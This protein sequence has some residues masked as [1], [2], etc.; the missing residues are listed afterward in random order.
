MRHLALLVLLLISSSLARELRAQASEPVGSE[1]MLT[2]GDSV[3]VIV[4]RKPEFSGEFAVAADGSVSHPLYRDVQVGGVSLAVAQ[5][6]MRAY[7]ERYDRAP[8]FVM[9]PLF[10]VA[11]QGEVYRP[12]VYAL[13]PQ[14]SIAEAVAQAG[15]PTQ[16]GRADRVRLV[17]T[18]TNGSQQQFRVDLTHPETGAARMPIRSGDQIVVERKRSVFSEVIVPALTIVGAAAS[19]GIFINNNTK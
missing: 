11:I 4:W 14:T 18:G 6:N 13:G 7:L 19:I 17:R 10:R 15:G 12:N 1:A 9:E 2:A 16:F 5:A 3:R 8:Q